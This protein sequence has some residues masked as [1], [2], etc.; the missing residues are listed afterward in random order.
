MNPFQQ[1]PW[2]RLCRATGI[3]PCKGVGA[4]TRSARSLGVCNNLCPF[5]GHGNKIPVLASTWRTIPVPI[6]K[7]THMSAG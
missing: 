7:V 1:M 2:N 6:P 4:A 5:Y 3:A